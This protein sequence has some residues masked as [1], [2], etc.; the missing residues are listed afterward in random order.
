MKN[1]KKLMVFMALLLPS[2][3]VFAQISTKKNLSDQDKV[4]GLSY[5]WSEVKYNFAYFDQAEINWDS[6]NHAFIS[7]V[8][9]TQNNW[10]YFLVLKELSA[11]LKDGHTD[12]YSLNNSIR[13][14]LHA[15]I[16]FSKAGDVIFVSNVV[17]QDNNMVPIGSQL[18]EIEGIKTLQWL[19]NSLFKYISASTPHERLN[20]AINSFYYVIPDTIS[21]LDMTFQTPNKSIINYTY[22]FRNSPLIWTKSNPITPIYNKE[23]KGDFAYLQLNSF[24]N[25]R[26]VSEFRKDIRDL[27]KTK[28][29]IIDLRNNGGGNTNNGDKI[30]MHFTNSDTLIG[31]KWKTRQHLASFKAWG[32]HYKK[33][34]PNII[35]QN[36]E[37]AEFYKK[38]FAIYE[39]DYWYEGGLHK[40]VNTTDKEL[41]NIPMIVLSGNKTASAA[42]DFLVTLK[43][44]PDRN[45]KI[46]GEKSFGSTGQPL[47]LELPGK[48]KARICTKRDIFKDGTDFVGT[49]IIPDIEIIPT[50]SDIIK[51]RDIVLEKAIETLKKQS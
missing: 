28:G 44:L 8:L 29:I 17:Q 41:R 22:R 21:T 4:A 2:V 23:M 11:Y 18:V 15:P 5:F 35:S 9:D 14:S 45:V 51:E 7:K 32:K 39:G 6:T 3:S 33:E 46:V 26:I 12:I 40:A 24:G 1:Y 47:Q 30:L 19:R 34:N 43:Q 16:R 38:V 48:I 49:G 37:Y 13:D 50:V 25:D 10:E 27:Q 42:E 31:S 20:E 36:D